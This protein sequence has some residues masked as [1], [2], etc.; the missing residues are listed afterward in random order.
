MRFIMFKINECLVR[1]SIAQ[2][3]KEGKCTVCELEDSPMNSYEKYLG[4]QNLCD[5]HLLEIC[6]VYVNHAKLVREFPQTYDEV[7]TSVL[8]PML[9]QRLGKKECQS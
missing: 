1:Q 6:E 5:E 2:L 4:F 3:V 9:I 8:F 7:I